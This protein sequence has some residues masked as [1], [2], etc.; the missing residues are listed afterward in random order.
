MDAAK[1]VTVIVPTFNERESVSELVARTTA[2]LAGYDAEILFVDDS[3]DDTP[4]EI[5]RV[6]SDAALPVR[7]LRRDENVGGLGGAVVAGLG[8]ASADV[9][10]VMD[11]DLQHPPEILP[12]SSSGTRGAT[13]MSSWPPATSVAA[14]RPDSARRSA[15]ASR[16]CRPCS[17]RRCF[18][19]GWRA[20]A[21]R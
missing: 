11:G 6:A 1:A 3:T 21:T 8:A 2:A 4:A 10:I 13:P 5:E 15:S 16:G 12:A 14:T 7:L 9:C 18:R 19:C 17:P 20:R